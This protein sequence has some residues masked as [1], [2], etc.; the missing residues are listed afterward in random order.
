MTVRACYVVNAVDETSVPADIARGLVEH[1]DA[2]VDILAWFAAEGFHGDDA[3][4][5]TCLDAPDTT[6]GIDRDT[7]RRA[8]EFLREYDVVQAHHNHSGSFA[9]AIGRRLGLPVVSRE[10]N[11]RRGF[12]RLGRVA[13]G[14]TNPLADRVVCNSRAVYDSFRRWERLA[15]PE[16]KVVFIPNGVEFDRLDAADGD[17]WRSAHGVDDDAVLVGTAGLLTEQKD[18]ATLIRAVAA[19]RSASDRPVELAIAG[20][21]PLEAD[22]RETARAAGVA[23]SVHFLGRLDRSAVYELLDALDVYAMPSRWEGFSAAAVEAVG[24]GTPCVFSTI[25]PFVEPYEEVARFHPVGDHEALA[26]HLVGLAADPAERRRL[27]SAG[28]DLVQRRY[29]VERVA[30]RY[31]SLYAEITD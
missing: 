29:T 31:R 7:Y 24:S 9:K 18:H 13:N 23:D 20:D 25:P 17:G 30:E 3:V 27:G 21:G 19:A 5:V 15:L 14:L 1:T 6:T 22:L 4:G 2:E 10:G 11:M 26:R 16:A 28:R 8:R 12:N